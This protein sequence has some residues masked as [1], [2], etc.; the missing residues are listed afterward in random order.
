MCLGQLGA[1]FV[2]LG[3]GVVVALGKV[4]LDGPGGLGFGLDRQNQGQGFITHI[5]DGGGDRAGGPERCGWGERRNKFC[6]VERRHTGGGVV[7]TGGGG[8]ACLEGQGAALQGGG[9]G[10]LL[11]GLVKQ[12]DQIKAVIRG[13]FAVLHGVVTGLAAGHGLNDGGILRGVHL[14]GDK[15]V[16]N[17]DRAVVG[18]AADNALG[19]FQGL[20]GLVGVVAHILFHADNLQIIC[21]FPCVARCRAG[22]GSLCPVRPAKVSGGWV[23]AWI[24]QPARR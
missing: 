19:A 12:L 18:H 4:C 15:A 11:H 1:E 20:C 17:I 23:S 22:V 10:G 21:F 7:V 2:G 9:V 24:F 3:G 6:V 5:G 8:L 14:V 16:G 13:L